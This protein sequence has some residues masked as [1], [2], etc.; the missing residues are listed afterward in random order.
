M[1]LESSCLRKGEALIKLAM[2]A[3]LPSVKILQLSLVKDS[4]SNPPANIAFSQKE[5]NYFWLIKEQYE[6]KTLKQQNPYEPESLA[7]VSWC[8]ARM[9]G[10]KGYNASSRPGPI[11]IKRGLEKFQIMMQARQIFEQDEDV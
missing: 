5:I 4:K 2:M 6:G 7:W 11:T 9:G 10:W 3:L 8:I 1:Q